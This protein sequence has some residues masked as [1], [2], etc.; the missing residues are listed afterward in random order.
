MV[1]TYKKPQDYARDVAIQALSGWHPIDSVSMQQRRNIAE[2]ELVPFSRMRGRKPDLV[3]TYEREV[4]EQE[5]EIM[6]T[7]LSGKEKRAWYNDHGPKGLVGVDALNWTI[8][9]DQISKGSVPPATEAPYGL[10]LMDFSKW[11]QAAKKAAR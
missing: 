2:L 5:T 4:E 3:I 10:S 6:P 9:Q 1:K 11:L 7:G 8:L